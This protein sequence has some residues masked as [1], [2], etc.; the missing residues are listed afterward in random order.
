M[1]AWQL[2]TWEDYRDVKRLGRKTRLSDAQRQTLW[3]VFDAVR[4]ELQAEGLV[5]MAGVFTRLAIEVSKRKHPPFEHVVL[6]EAQDVTVAQ[7]KFL[8]AV[9][10]TR[11]NSLFFAGDLGQRIFQTAF[12]WKSLGVDIRGRSRTLTVNYRTSHQIRSQADRLLGEEIADV[13][14]NTE[15]R[16]GNVLPL[17]RCTCFFSCAFKPVDTAGCAQRLYTGNAGLLR[18]HFRA[19]KVDPFAAIC[20]RKTAA[21]CVRVSGVGVVNSGTYTG[22]QQQLF[23]LHRRNLG[24]QS[25]RLPVLPQHGSAKIMKCATSWLEGGRYEEV[26]KRL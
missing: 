11:P 18:S 26:K 13:D 19:F 2:Q 23:A 1:D 8:A 22:E 4:Q 7:L 17:G 10:D 15:S 20:S 21:V 5:S 16:K 25:S 9:G 14:G 6:D 3:S 12:S 24:H